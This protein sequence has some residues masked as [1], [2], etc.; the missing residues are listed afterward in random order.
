MLYPTTIVDTTLQI[1]DYLKDSPI[2]A[3]IKR[4][5]LRILQAQNRFNPYELILSVQWRFRELI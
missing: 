2:E 5:H 1:I 4:T 3:E